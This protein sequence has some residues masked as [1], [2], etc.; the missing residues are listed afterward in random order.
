MAHTRPIPL[1]PKAPVGAPTKAR[2]HSH[3]PLV[4]MPLIQR[5]LSA[6]SPEMELSRGPYAPGDIGYLQSTIGN[7]AVQRLLIDPE[8]NNHERQ[9]NAVQRA[10]GGGENAPQASLA[11]GQEGGLVHPAVENRLQHSRHGG[12]PLSPS[13][14]AK[15]Q[16]TLQADLKNVRLHTDANAVQLARDLNA[17]AFTFKNHIFYG[18]DASPSN[19]ALT[20]H[21]AA[22]T[23]QQG[24]V[25]R[26]TEPA[27]GSKS[28][29]S[30][31]TALCSPAIQ[32]LPTAAQLESSAGVAKNDWKL[33]KLTL[34]RMST[35]YKAVLN[36]LRD[37]D[38]VMGER[39]GGDLHGYTMGG[40]WDIRAELHLDDVEQTVDTYLAA[41]DDDDRA[42]QI[43]AIKA[44]IPK[45]RA[46]IAYIRANMGR[47]TNMNGREAIEMAMT[48][49]AAQDAAS[50]GTFSDNKDISDLRNVLSGNNEE[51]NTSLQE[52]IVKGR[53]GAQM[54]TGL[55]G[56]FRGSDVL[57]KVSGEYSKGN[58]LSYY[59]TSVIPALLDVIQKLHGSGIGA[60]NVMVANPENPQLQNEVRTE[61]STV[62]SRIAEIYLPFARTL[63]QALPDQLINASAMVYARVRSQTRQEST[64]FSKDMAM[65]AATNMI[66]V[67]C[68]GPALA[69]ISGN[70]DFKSR[71]NLNE[72][73][74]LT[75]I[76]QMVAKQGPGVGLTANRGSEY[77][78]L[79]AEPAIQAAAREYNYILNLIS[80]RGENMLR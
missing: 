34:R 30:D 28:N 10:V 6:S 29:G 57:S 65:K 64:D 58:F 39:V 13:M 59:L 35:K 8:R 44:E 17:K 11:S 60:L 14:R 63:V 32:R 51:A 7:R 45:E 72:Q 66:Y 43:R 54:G 19:V 12:S 53:Q 42:G 76:V 79:G 18:E 41:H 55:G 37:Y 4:Q 22:H 48:L 61:D 77:E 56:A 24:A 26:L 15:L 33:G 16:P 40:A 71:L 9:A 80:S 62:Y 46:A 73:M 75:A 47:F 5:L 21:E 78:R 70:N 31:P 27:I 69:S 23:V 38:R 74:A 52:E 1:K 50:V 36:K 67:R 3:T 68:F 49:K 2:D 20:A 25:P